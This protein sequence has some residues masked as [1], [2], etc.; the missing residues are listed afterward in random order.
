MVK[1]KKEKKDKQERRL[2]YNMAAETPPENIFLWYFLII[3]ESREIERIKQRMFEELKPVHEEIPFDN[4]NIGNSHGLR[5]SLFCLKS[6]RNEMDF[7]QVYS[8]RLIKDR[9]LYWRESNFSLLN[10]LEQE[11]ISPTF[12]RDHEVSS[13]ENNHNSIDTPFPDYT[14]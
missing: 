8:G 4:G 5:Y 9:R 14:M 12:P 7:S 10:V 11:G 3:N 6:S 13:P 1:Y 2:H